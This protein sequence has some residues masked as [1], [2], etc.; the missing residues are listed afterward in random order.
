[1]LQVHSRLSDE[2]EPVNEAFLLQLQRHCA[3]RSHLRSHLDRGF[4]PPVCLM[5]KQHSGLQV[6]QKCTEHNFLV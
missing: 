6:I 3:H 5:G 4:Q 2:G 1:M